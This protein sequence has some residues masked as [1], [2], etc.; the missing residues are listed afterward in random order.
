MTQATR[1][2]LA[3][4]GLATAAAL[5][6]A[7]AQEA[8]TLGLT[9]D[10]Q[11]AATIVLAEKPTRSAQLAAAELQEHVRLISGAALPVAN[12]AAEVKGTRILVGESKAT[13]A[14]G[15]KNADFKPQEYLIRFAPDL[16]VL[17]GRDKEDFAKLDYK[18]PDGVT[19][20]SGFEE[21]GTCYA[22]Y[23]FLERHCGVRWYLPTD[24]GTVY[25]PA[26]TLK[27]TG[28]ERRRMPGM[29]LRSGLYDYH[30]KLRAPYQDG[31][32]RLPVDLIGPVFG[33]RNE[34]LPWRE[35][36]LFC[37]RM[38]QG[39][40]EGCP[41]G[42][43]SFYGYYARFWEQDKD[44]ARAKLF[45]G[46]HPEFFAQGYEGRP[47]KMC[48]S[49]E[50]LVQQVA[51]DARTF[52]DGKW[53]VQQENNEP[54][55]GNDYFPIG[56]MD[57]GGAWCKCPD[58][59]ALLAKGAIGWQG[60][61]FH[62]RRSGQELL[63]AFVNRVAR[64]VAKTHPDKHLAT[65]DYGPGTK[66]SR[67]EKLEPNVAMGR[68]MNPRRLW[69][70][71]EWH[72]N[73]ECM[74]AWRTDS[75]ER[76]RYLWFHYLFPLTGAAYTANNPQ[77]NALRGAPEWYPFPGFFA[78]KVVE[79]MALYR[80]YG[81]RG[82]YVEISSAPPAGQ[83]LWLWDQLEVYVTLQL[84]FDP[85]QDGNKLIDE[86]FARYYGAAAKP[87]QG[88]YEMVEEIYCNPNNYPYM[89]PEAGD[90]DEKIAWEYL[91][92]EPRMDK[93]ERLMKEAHALAQT[94][95]AKARV[96]LFDKGVWQVM[97]KG[98][99]SHLAKQRQPAA[100]APPPTLRAPF[101]PAP[102]DRDPR[103]L[104]WQQ[105]GILRPWFTFDGQETT[106]QV[107]GRVLQDGEFLYL[108]LQERLDTK[109][110]VRDDASVFGG[111]CWEIFV[112]GARAAYG[113]TYSQLA[114]DAAGKTQFL[115]YG[116]MPPLPDGWE[117]GRQVYSD[118]AAPDAWTVY[119]VMPLD[120][121]LP[122]EARVKPGDT[123]YLNIV[124]STRGQ[125]EGAAMWVATRERT[126]HATG[127]LGAVLIERPDGGSFLPGQ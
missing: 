24:L 111:D 126:F 82:Y 76:P 16:L 6:S 112:A 8:V 109:A 90:Q 71:L 43:H 39:G 40:I 63:L 119:A 121:L 34:V 77:N 7:Q 44:P 46:S 93:L 14:L 69:N 45:E 19:I 3:L 57:D 50:A 70:T 91:G 9:R 97:L 96:A 11:P 88:F 83:A 52:F 124:R 60:S 99:Q 53:V 51:K 61:Y 92:T 108:R 95:P 106:R 102:P 85:S 30:P 29:D 74:Q 22:A 127:R 84:A 115:T 56:D 25:D 80:H 68:V 67:L 32:R 12:D 73:L 122:G 113:A 48:L 15:L 62:G 123:V 55:T 98:R 26:P 72:H 4:V 65:Y 35:Q 17:M 10:G 116:P 37:R 38:R 117:H 23:D 47:P 66:P 75:P 101:C 33:G 110:L 28:T 78:H 100:A 86:F 58:C 94:E 105:A 125:V 118:A 104:D 31:W 81:Y 54:W 1:I 5:G 64:E 114:L 36:V 42:G 79:Q 27:V 49:S 2:R 21:Q 18:N 13:Q 59:Q 107:E 103:K 41:A 20:P 87:M 89:T 120:R